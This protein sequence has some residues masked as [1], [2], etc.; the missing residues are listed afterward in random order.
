MAGRPMKVFLLPDA[1]QQ[2]GDRRQGSGRWG[3][4]GIDTVRESSPLTRRRQWGRASL[5]KSD[6]VVLRVV[7]AKAAGPREAQG[8]VHAVISSISLTSMTPA[9]R[10]APHGHGLQK[11]R[12]KLPPP[13]R[14]AGK[15]SVENLGL[16]EGPQYQT[17]TC[18][19]V[20]HS[21][22][23][24]GFEPMLR[25]APDIGWLQRTGG[26]ALARPQHK[27]IRVP[28]SAAG[29]RA[30]AGSWKTRGG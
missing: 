24:K 7:T 20:I 25:K 30:T 18:V 14:Q 10:P 1:S 2:R 11:T 8:V 19:E 13:A 23:P 5:G 26:T 17:S 9:R 29:H 21:Q 3:S 15:I 27:G 28:R 6:A 22:R 16:V 12:A 4:L